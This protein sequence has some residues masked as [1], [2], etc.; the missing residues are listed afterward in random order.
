MSLIFVFDSRQDMTRIL[1]SVVVIPF[2]RRS[3]QERSASV[4]FLKKAR[5][6]CAEMSPQF[7]QLDYAQSDTLPASGG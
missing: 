4:A 7:F 5:S 3:T 6:V 1:L 2:D